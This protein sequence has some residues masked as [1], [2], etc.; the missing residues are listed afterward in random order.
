MSVEF[1]LAGSGEEHV[2]GVLSSA[3]QEVVKNMLREC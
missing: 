1:G 3:W 2:E